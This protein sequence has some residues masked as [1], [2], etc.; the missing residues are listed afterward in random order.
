M[1]EIARNCND[2]H[3]RVEFRICAHVIHTYTTVRIRVLNVWNFDS[4]R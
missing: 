4:L 3:M 1:S 2:Y